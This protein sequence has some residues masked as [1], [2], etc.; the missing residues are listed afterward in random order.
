[1]L[2]APRP[3]LCPI[4]WLVM[5]IRRAVSALLLLPLLGALAWGAGF[6]W[7]LHVTGRTEPPPPLADGIVALT[8]GAER[9]EAALRLLAEDRAQR[10]LI[11][12]VS[13]G[14]ELAELTHHAD[15]GALGERITL[16]RQANSTYGNGT[17]TASWAQENGMRSLIVVTAAY[18]MPRALT[19]IGR[20]LPGVRL[21]PVAV[22][23]PPRRGTNDSGT[24]G[25]LAGEY[26]KWL[27]AEAGLGYLSRG[28]PGG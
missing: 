3:I 26:T 25:M 8:G 15:L 18:H 11:S 6:L 27:A 23:P 24:Y 9:V 20:A 4:P 28:H 16:G 22:L 10:L 21:Y 12:G 1:M 7:F 19:E 13:R 17:E 5:S 14:I 2:S